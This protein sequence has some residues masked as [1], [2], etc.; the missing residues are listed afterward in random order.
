MVDNLTRPQRSLC[1]SHIQS[2]NTKP[3][4]KI[5][6][7]VHSLGYRFR[8]HRNDL[9]GKPDLIFPRLKKVIFVHGC[10]WHNHACCN[11][12]VI[13]QTNVSYWKEKRNKTVNRDRKSLSELNKLG[14]QVKIIWECQIRKMTDL[15]SVLRDFLENE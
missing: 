13:P 3:E 7:I 14:W 15:E 12:R 1:M 8:L 11:G 9:P 6:S 4:I 10:F 2:K 5:R